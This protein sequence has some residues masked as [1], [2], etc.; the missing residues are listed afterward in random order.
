MRTRVKTEQE[1]VVREA[2]KSELAKVRA[3]ENIRAAER[4]VEE[5][6]QEMKQETQNYKFELELKY[7]TLI[8]NKESEMRQTMAT[9]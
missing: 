4:M 5:V 1:G 7:Q 8:Q 9:N 3:E 6:K 2:K